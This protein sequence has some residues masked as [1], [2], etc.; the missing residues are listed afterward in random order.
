[1]IED[2]SWNSIFDEPY[3]DNFPIVFKVFAGEALKGWCLFV[4]VKVICFESKEKEKS[5]P[6]T[7]I[8]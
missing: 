8:F 7:G 3:G 2:L 4:E 1:M 5:Q 6:P